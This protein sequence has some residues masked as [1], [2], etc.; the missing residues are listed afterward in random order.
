MDTHYRQATAE[1]RTFYTQK[2]YPLQDQIF[3]LTAL[4]GNKLYLTGGTALA[5][6]YF[7]HRLSED[8]DFF[9]TTDD[10]RVIAN[11]LRLRLLE[12][13][14]TVET[15]KLEI[16]FARL[17][18]QQAELTLKIEFAKEF[19]L[20]DPLLATP[21]GIYINSLEDLGANKISAFED[22]AA[23]KDIIDL[24]YITQRVALPRLFEL[25]DSKRIPVE[26]EHLLAIN[27]GG[28]TGQALVTHD[29]PAEALHEF[30][31]HLKAATEAEVKKKEQQRTAN[32][33]PLIRRLLWEFPSE[34]RTINAQS[35]PVLQQRLHT[36]SLPDRRVLSRR[37]TIAQETPGQRSLPT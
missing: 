3:E 22:R 7:Q 10:L 20:V 16:Y 37:L 5:R 36:L 23:I 17:Y 30:L 14:F 26:Y 19:N 13:G 8:L 11:D 21:H 18:V 6:F 25:A 1:E 9:T 29:L 24:Y 28:I 34:L 2:L 33:D 4:Y 35:I 31:S 32:L 15:E 27:T 12:R